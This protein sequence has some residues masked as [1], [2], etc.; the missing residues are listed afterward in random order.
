MLGPTP[1]CSFDGMVQRIRI[2][3]NVEGAQRILTVEGPT[4]DTDAWSKAL[5]RS[6]QP[7]SKI[8]PNTQ[9]ST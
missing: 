3:C 2:S 8:V 5:R 4:V 1:T 7:G 9:P 6:D